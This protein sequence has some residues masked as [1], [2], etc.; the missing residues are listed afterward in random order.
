MKPST[1]VMVGRAFGGWDVMNA[2]RAVDVEIREVLIGQ[3][4]RDQSRLDKFIVDLDGTPSKKR[5]GGNACVAVS[6][7]CAHAAAKAEGIALWEHLRGE[8]RRMVKPSCRCR[9]YRFS[10]AVHMHP[11]VSTCRISW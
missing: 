7:A 6:M 9:K 4:V 1:C 2:V 10:V 3:D 8:D 5:L 11:I